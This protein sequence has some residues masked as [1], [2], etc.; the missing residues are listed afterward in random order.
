MGQLLFMRKLVTEESFVM[1]RTT[2]S[3]VVCHLICICRHRLI[4]EQ[5]ILRIN[6]LLPSSCFTL[7]CDAN[8]NCK[9]I[10]VESSVLFMLMFATAQNL[11]HTQS[12]ISCGLL[13]NNSLHRALCVHVVVPAYAIRIPLVSQIID[14]LSL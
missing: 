9:L 4:F 8:R 3:R 13:V 5:E 7:N 1:M 2:F 6:I 14:Y 10:I 12:R 11:S